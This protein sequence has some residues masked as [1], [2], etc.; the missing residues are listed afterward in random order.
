MALPKDLHPTGDGPITVSV[1][2]VSIVKGPGVP[3]TQKPSSEFQIVSAPPNTI[4]D[5]KKFNYFIAKHASSTALVVDMDS[6]QNLSKI[7]FDKIPL[8]SIVD[9]NDKTVNTFYRGTFIHS[10]RR[11][12][13]IKP[14]DLIDLAKK[15]KFNKLCVLGTSRIFNWWDRYMKQI[16]SDT[17]SY[18][19]IIKKLKGE[20][21][22]AALISSPNEI[23]EVMARQGD[24]W[25]PVRY[26]PSSRTCFP[27]PSE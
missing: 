12:A 4:S 17:S 6:W 2:R 11:L 25:I 22:E 5:S 21:E 8:I 7:P 20:K 19:A 26:D 14:A 24:N 13:E 16:L 23:L 9:F 18:D 10:S 3:N 1:E 15:K 27:I